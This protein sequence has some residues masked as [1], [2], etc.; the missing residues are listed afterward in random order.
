MSHRSASL[1]ASLLVALALTGCP[2]DPATD[3]G[4]GTDA[5]AGDDAPSGEDAP[6]ALDAGSDAPAATDA[7]APTGC[8]GTARPDVSGVRGTEGLIVARDGTIYYS[9]RAA[10]GRL[11]PTGGPENAWVSLPSG[12]STVWGIALDAANETLYVGSP[13]TGTIYSVDLRLDTPVATVFVA[14]AGAP[15]GLTVGPDGALYYSDFS[16]GRV[17]RVE[18][19]GGSPTQV[20]TSGVRGANGVAFDGDG[21]LLVCSYQTGTL[22]RL[23]LS[24]GVESARATVATSLGAPDGV[25]VDANGDL[26]VTDNSAGRVL[27]VNAATG[28]SEVIASGISAAASL[29]FGAGELGC[30]DV[31][32]AS[33]GAARRLEDVGVEGADVLWH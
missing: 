24:A 25:A 32:V 4:L 17:M 20:T 3:A 12:A 2:S 18:A 22:F 33:S 19:T 23:T 29:D 14:G 27:R 16:G 21:T 13:A 26:W 30:S 10:V 31:Y 5:P 1:F 9:Q 7:G 6:V 11:T 15:N 28:A 8:T